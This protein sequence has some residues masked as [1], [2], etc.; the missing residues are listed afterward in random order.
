MP[1][2]LLLLC[3]ACEALR[4][5]HRYSNLHL[6]S[7][8]RALGIYVNVLLHVCVHRV[9][10][11]FAYPHFTSLF[12]SENV[13]VCFSGWICICAMSRHYSLPNGDVEPFIKRVVHAS[14]KT[15]LLKPPRLLMSNTRTVTPRAMQIHD[16][17]LLI[18]SADLSQG[19]K[20]TA[21][22]AAGVSRFKVLWTRHMTWV[23]MA[24]FLLSPHPV[25]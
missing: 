13:G 8:P 15:A 20:V 18:S 16:R 10:C 24:F 19:A 21:A 22:T 5:H 25:G 11:E 23:I 6:P 4:P 14:E 3:I 7:T 2:F 9:S 12:V 17:L 1:S